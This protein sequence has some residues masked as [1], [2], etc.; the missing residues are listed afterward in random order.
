MPII[1]LSNLKGGTGKTT[2]SFC[3]AEALRRR[4]QTVE[5]YDLDPQGS[6]TE[7]AYAAEENDTPLNFSVTVANAR[8]VV[9]APRSNHWVIVDC[10][11]G[12]TAQIDAAIATADVVIVPVS[13][14]PIDVNR[15]W[16]TLDL[17]APEKSI[18]LVCRAVPNTRLGRFIVEALEED[19]EA[20]VFRTV[21]PQREAI[22]AL[23]GTALADDLYGYENVAHEL[24]E[25][26]QK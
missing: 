5:V 25:R 21:I 18:V 14:S 2:S 15:M 12:A 16:K 9:K 6:A 23:F 10:P 19:D 22:K 7:W 13:P 3:L 1:A 24:M 17:A 26:M 11:P 8:T 20:Q 4:G